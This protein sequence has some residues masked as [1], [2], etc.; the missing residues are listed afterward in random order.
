MISIMFK[1]FCL[2]NSSINTEA[3]VLICSTNYLW[4]VGV[5]EY[6]RNLMRN[7]GYFMENLSF[8]PSDFLKMCSVTLSSKHYCCRETCRKLY[9]YKSKE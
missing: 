5:S 8:S 7:L 3:Q 9:M 6:K 2:I 1:L 4:S